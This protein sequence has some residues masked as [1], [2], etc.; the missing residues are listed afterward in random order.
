VGVLFVVNFPLVRGVSF[1]M[2]RLFFIFLVCCSFQVASAFA[3]Q[4]LVKFYSEVVASG[5]LYC[6]SLELST[7][8]LED[9]APSGSVKRKSLFKSYSVFVENN[10][11]NSNLL[12]GFV[13]FGLSDV[14]AQGKGGLRG[15]TARRHDRDINLT[16]LPLLS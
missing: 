12:Q 11:M 3:P 9:N 14:M 7:D 8:S 13:L 16:N 2:N 10:P 4:S 6:E 5:G 1:S 15:G